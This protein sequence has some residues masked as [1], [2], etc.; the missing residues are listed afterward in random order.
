MHVLGSGINIA[1][2]LTAYKIPKKKAGL[3]QNAEGRI[4]ERMLEGRAD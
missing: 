1:V 4:D 3:R 2:L